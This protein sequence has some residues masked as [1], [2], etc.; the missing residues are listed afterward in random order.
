MIIHDAD[1]G[2]CYPYLVLTETPVVR[3]LPTKKLPILVR[4]HEYLQQPN[5][6]TLSPTLDNG[7]GIVKQHQQ[8]V[9]SH[10]WII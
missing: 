6:R 3:S 4:E 8:V 9:V 10:G 7:I 2:L 5:L 1:V